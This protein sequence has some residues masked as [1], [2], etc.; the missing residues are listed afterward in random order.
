MK[1]RTRIIAK[2]ILFRGSI[3][4]AICG[5]LYIYFGSS[6]F[7]IYEY[8]LSGVPDNYNQEIVSQIKEANSKNLFYILPGDR[9]ISFHRKDIKNIIK[10]ILP[11]TDKISFSL[12]GLHSLKISVSP[13]VPIFRTD[14]THAI[15][16]N[17][18]MY[19]E[20]T[21]RS[22]L[23]IVQ[24]ATSTNVN[25][26]LLTSLA[27]LVPK[28]NSVLYPVSKI[29]ID[30]YGDIRL[31]DE[32]M[33]HAIILSVSADMKKTWSNIISA[34]DTEP[35]K[36]KL[37]NNKNDLEYLDTRFGNKVF[38][39]FTKHGSTDIIYGLPSTDTN[40]TTTSSTTPAIV[41]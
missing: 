12:G 29:T 20:M 1:K 16:K 23:P 33:R 8:Q 7:S 13:Y 38:Y 2:R 35:L 25:E 4:L 28:V 31:Y 3:L 27:D 18:I 32:S 39:K 15:T 17:G 24:M 41:Q 19:E 10:N 40:A 21:L 36:S 37:E 5:L 6:A 9:I 22:D 14:T 34:I 11:N 30:E 26:K